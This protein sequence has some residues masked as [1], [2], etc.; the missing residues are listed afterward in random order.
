MS[1][2]TISQAWPGLACRRPAV[3]RRRA[4]PDASAPADLTRGLRH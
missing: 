4:G 2:V 3:H 1:V